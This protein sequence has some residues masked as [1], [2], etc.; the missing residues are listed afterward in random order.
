MDKN[1]T[2]AQQ[3]RAFWT[4]QT[5]AWSYGYP[6]FTFG[7]RRFWTRTGLPV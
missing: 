2:A 6:Q 4:H 5:T 7:T 1:V 3:Q